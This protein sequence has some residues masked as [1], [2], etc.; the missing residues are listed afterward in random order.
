MINLLSSLIRRFFVSQSTNRQMSD[1]V[2]GICARA[3][4]RRN[5]HKACFFISVIGLIASFMTEG[6]AP[7]PCYTMEYAFYNL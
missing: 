3:C 2:T 5:W 4:F 6:M 1:N 7:I